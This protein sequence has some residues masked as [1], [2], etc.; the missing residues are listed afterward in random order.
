M[1]ERKRD[2]AGGFGVPRGCSG[3][4]RLGTSRGVLMSVLIV[5]SC[6]DRGQGL[7]RESDSIAGS[8][9]RRSSLLLKWRVHLVDDNGILQ[10]P[11]TPCHAPRGSGSAWAWL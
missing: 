7:S 10:M 6:F 11:K 4:R 1:R 9:L 8:F 5:P 2:F 3:A